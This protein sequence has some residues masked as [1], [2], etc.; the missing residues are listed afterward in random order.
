MKSLFLLLFFIFASSRSFWH[1]L[2]ISIV[3]GLDFPCTLAAFR[4]KIAFQ[5]FPMIPMIC[6][7]FVSFFDFFAWNGFVQILC[8]GRKVSLQLPPIPHHASHERPSHMRPVL[9]SKLLSV[10]ICFHGFCN[11]FATCLQNAHHI[12]IIFGFRLFHISV[13][14]RP[15]KPMLDAL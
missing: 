2:F 7:W 3:N 10:F 9:R 6:I 13:L 14:W 8:T 12:T 5:W 1:H 15:F 11:M 4:T